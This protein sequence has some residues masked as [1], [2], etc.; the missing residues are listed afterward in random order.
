[1][2]ISVTA[3]AD[4]WCSASTAATSSGRSLFAKANAQAFTHRDRAVQVAV[5]KACTPPDQVVRSQPRGQRLGMQQHLAA[6]LSREVVMRVEERLHEREPPWRG[7]A[8][9]RLRCR[10]QILNGH[11][12]VGRL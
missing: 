3:P 11:D 1:M 7:R 9:S 10:E 2:R 12:P 6:A 8:A 4:A 5:V